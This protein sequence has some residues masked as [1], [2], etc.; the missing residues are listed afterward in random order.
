MKIQL[1][2]DAVDEEGAGKLTHAIYIADKLFLFRMIEKRNGL[3]G[4]ALEIVERL[5]KRLKI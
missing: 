3:D 4:L 5:K 1:R 2:F